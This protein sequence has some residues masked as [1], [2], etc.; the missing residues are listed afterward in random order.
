[1]KKRTKIIIASSVVLTIGLAGAGVGYM[2]LKKNPTM[3]NLSDVND[4]TLQSKTLERDPNKTIQ[5]YINNKEY[6]E[7]LYIANGIL[8]ETKYWTST[9]EGEAVSVG[10]KQ[11]VKAKR[12]INNNFAFIRTVI[13]I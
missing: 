7:I 10:Q 12:I 2:F 5:D 8:D 6:K 13:Q 4:P 3:D 11:P 9:A 1:M